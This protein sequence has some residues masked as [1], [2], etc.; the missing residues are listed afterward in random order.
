[1]NQDQLSSLVRTALKIL[2]ALI[3]ST[4]LQNAG[5][6]DAAINTPDVIGLVSL[7]AGMVWSHFSH[8]GT[9]P[10][11]GATGGSPSIK[12]PLLL[13]LCCAVLCLAP[14]C[15]P[16]QPGADPIIVQTER[17][18][19]V[20]KASFDLILHADNTDRAFWETNAPA[21]HEFCEWLR[22]PI[23]IEGTNTLPR[24]SALILQLDD[25][26]L[27]YE[28]ARTSSNALWVACTTF[29]G[30][31]SQAQAWQ[32]VILPPKT[33]DPKPQTPLLP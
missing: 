28:S 10:P 8:T 6:L 33:P 15:S 1:M 24:A 19:T 26:K 21:F 31:V 12:L 9:P 17:A 2:G 27:D 11:T 29:Q 13:A 14:G 7:I 22:Q 20:G 5:N 30:L 3:V 18:E 4:G 25:V 16:I 23:T 32:T